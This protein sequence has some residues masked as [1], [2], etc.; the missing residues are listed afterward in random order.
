MTLHCG[1]LGPAGAPA[2]VVHRQQQR[3]QRGQPGQQ[4]VGDD[5]DVG[6]DPG[7]QP[8][9]G[10]AVEGPDRMVGNHHHGPLGRD[11]FEFLFAQTDLEA[12]VLQHL[13]HEVEPAQ[14][15]IASGKVDEGLLVEQ[16]A[17]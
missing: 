8:E 16:I 6:P 1:Q 5:A 9:Q 3:G 10:Q 12:K 17:Q 2:Q 7:N 13:F 11:V 15:G 14:V 4:L